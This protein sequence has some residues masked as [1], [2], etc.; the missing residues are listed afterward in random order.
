MARDLR[1]RR[2]RQTAREIQQAALRLSLRLGHDAVTA[3]A[4]AAEAGIS[5]RTFFNYYNNKQAAILGVPPRLDLEASEWFV[6][7]RQPLMDD[8]VQ[9]LGEMLDEDR[10]DRDLMRLIKQL[11]EAEPPLLPL[12]HATLE[13][14]SQDLTLLLTRRLGPGLEAQAHLIATLAASALSLA[15]R[16]WAADDS[17]DESRIIASMRQQL[18]DVCGCLQKGALTCPPDP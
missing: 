11:I 6:H 10:L 1:E 7:S 15:V 16:K 18:V 3:D 9:V 12:F 17:M 14:V 5:P 2:R 13:R 4:I 8:V